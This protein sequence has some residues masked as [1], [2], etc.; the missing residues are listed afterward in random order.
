MTNMNPK[1]SPSK[2]K[3]LLWSRSALQ[4]NIWVLSLSLSKSTIIFFSSS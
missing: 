4:S 3:F 1:F 2:Y